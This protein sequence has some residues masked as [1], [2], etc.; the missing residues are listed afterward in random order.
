MNFIVNYH[1]FN[2]ENIYLMDLNHYDK[3]K[4]GNYIKLFYKISKDVDIDLIV[5]TPKMFIPFGLCKYE[6]N[7]IKNKYKYYID[8]SF[9]NYNNNHNINMFYQKITGLDKY[10]SELVRDT[11]ESHPVMANIFKNDNNP[12]IN[13]IRNNKDKTNLPSTFKIK[14]TKNDEF[15]VVCK[16]HNKD[17]TITTKKNCNLENY[18]NPNM[19]VSCIIRC[20]GIW[21]QNNK[22]GMTW[23]LDKISVFEN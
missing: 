14:I 19:Y 8:L 18:I 22:F 15:D 16:I 11:Y 3:N 4:K 10:I 7:N 20:N 2:P 1:D 17:G 5:N 13:Q 21:F 9:M 6:E 23:K 12:Y